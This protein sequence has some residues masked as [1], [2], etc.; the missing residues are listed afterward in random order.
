VSKT[1][2]F[3]LAG[4]L[5]GGMGGG[6]GGGFTKTPQ[7]KVQASAFIDSYNE[8]VVSLRNYKAHTVNG[9]LGTGGRLGV[10]RWL[11]GSG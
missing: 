4:G 10:P 11:N 3:G 1:V 7:D 6:G 2:D 8:M 5:F 9:G